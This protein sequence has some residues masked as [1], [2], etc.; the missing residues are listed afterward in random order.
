MLV[1]ADHSRMTK[2]SRRDR[3]ILHSICELNICEHAISTAEVPTYYS[4]FLVLRI[5]WYDSNLAY[6]N[7]SFN[8]TVKKILI[9]ID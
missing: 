3:Q 2:N 1:P 9:E 8:I 6:Y 5:I 4:W 7:N